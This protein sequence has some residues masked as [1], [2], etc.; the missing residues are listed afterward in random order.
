VFDGIVL[1]NKAV[2]GTVNAGLADYRTGAEALAAADRGWLAGLVTRRVPLDHF[3]EALDKH[4][5]DV[6]VVIDLG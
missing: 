4:E 1:H 6:K 5:D 2:V 3:T